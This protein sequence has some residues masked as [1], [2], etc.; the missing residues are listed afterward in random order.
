MFSLCLFGVGVGFMLMAL[1]VVRFRYLCTA[2]GIVSL[3]FYGL[4]TIV[5]IAE[6]LKVSGVI[7]INI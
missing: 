5:F 2:F 3:V 1:L 6:I 4:A 7:N